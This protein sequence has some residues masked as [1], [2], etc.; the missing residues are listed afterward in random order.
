MEVD[1][2]TSLAGFA[3]GLA[4]LAGIVLVVGVDDLVDALVRADPSTAALVVLAA[5]G[6]LSAWALALRTVLG[7]LG[8]PIPAHVAVGVFAAATFANNVTPFGQAGGE[9]VSAAFISRIADTEYE[10]G[11]AAIA[12]VDSLNFVPSIL[13]ASLGL[14][15]FSTRLA[16][17]RR[18]RIAALAIGLLALAVPVAGYVGWRHRYQVEA[19]ITRALTPVVRR[20]G[21]LLPNRQP[22][23]IEGIEARVEGF[24]HNIERVAGDRSGLAVALSLSTLGWLCQI[25]SLWLSLSALGNTVPVAVVAVAVPVGAIA[26]VTPLPGGLGGVEAVLVALLAALGIPASVAGAAVVLHRGATYW[27]PMLVGGGVATS[28]G[29]LDRGNWAGDGGD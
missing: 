26:G 10:S 13:L 4:V 15:F 1:L 8:S 22:P 27:L 7:V 17:G 18:L 21:G 25:A 6:W 28:L 23:S 3:G 24:F 29:A 5:V 19:R 14:A 16:F 9:P 2:R 20:I 11:L 12:S